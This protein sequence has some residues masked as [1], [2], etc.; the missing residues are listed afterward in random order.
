MCWQ[1]ARYVASE[2]SPADWQHLR[3]CMHVVP[4]DFSLVCH[5]VAAYLIRALETAPYLAIILL[6][7]CMPQLCR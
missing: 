4:C 7:S 3:D 2:W 5:G 6:H 1:T